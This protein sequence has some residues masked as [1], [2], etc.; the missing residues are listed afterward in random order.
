[1]TSKHKKIEETFTHIRDNWKEEDYKN[2]HW[3]GKLINHLCQK[4]LHN[5]NVV[6]VFS[7]GLNDFNCQ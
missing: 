7:N 2:V 4:N 5:I 3:K 6:D 1:M